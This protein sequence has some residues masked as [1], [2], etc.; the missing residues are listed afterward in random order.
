MDKDLFKEYIKESELDKRD[1]GYA[2]HT[3]IGLQSYYK[4]N[5]ARDASDRTEAT[6]KASAFFPSALSALRRTS[7]F[8][9]TENYSMGSI[10]MHAGF[11]ITIS[12]RKNGCRRGTTVLYGSAMGFRAT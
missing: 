12:R 3:V 10:L 9:S 1:K 2:W 6:G 8:P 7:I 4:E 11:K 5:P